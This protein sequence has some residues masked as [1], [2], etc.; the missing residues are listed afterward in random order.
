MRVVELDGVVVQLVRG[1]LRQGHRGGG[2]AGAVSRRAH[3]G[4]H[5]LPPWGFPSRDLR[6]CLLLLKWS[7]FSKG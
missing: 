6:L 7:D 4:L 3:R 2:P 1:V 5:G